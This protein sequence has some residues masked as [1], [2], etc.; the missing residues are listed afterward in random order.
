MST[1]EALQWND[2][3]AKKPDSDIT[4]LCWGDEGYF[5]GWWDDAEGQWHA[6]ESG[7]VVD[8]ITH[9]SDPQGPAAQ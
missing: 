7:G 4:V 2:A 1:S 3:K 6:C 9:W 8:H 5:C